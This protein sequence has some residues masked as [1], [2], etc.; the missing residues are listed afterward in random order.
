MK[1]EFELEGRLPFLLARAPEVSRLNEYT[2]TSTTLK[3][4][5]TANDA[6]PLPPLAP[7]AASVNMSQ[8]MWFCRWK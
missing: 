5:S 1:H 7:R 3:R 6:R 4:S 8:R 2:S